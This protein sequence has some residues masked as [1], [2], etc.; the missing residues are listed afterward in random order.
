[1]YGR[2]PFS[3][4]PIQI[5]TTLKLPNV[6]SSYPFRFVPI[7]IYT[8]LKLSQEYEKLPQRFVPIQIYTTLKP[9]ISEKTAYE[10]L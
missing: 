4:V 1:M 3:F 6:R 9:Q 10:P 5:Y 7:Q 2:C 8:T